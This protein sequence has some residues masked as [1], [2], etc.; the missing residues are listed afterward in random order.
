MKNKLVKL[1]VFV[2]VLAGAFYIFKLFY[3]PDKA[4]VSTSGN[5]GEIREGDLIFQSSF[6]EQGKAIQ[7]A[8]KSVYTHCGIIYKRN[9]KYYVYEAVQPVKLT[10]LDQWIARG[11][12]HHYVIK[13]LSNA[14]QVLIPEA[15]EK[16]KKE[17]EKFLGKN[18][19]STFEWSDTRIYCSE[20]IWKIYKRGT[21]VEIGK[22]EKLKDFDLTGAEVKKK[23]KERY[24]ENIP[25]EETV[26][27]PASVFNSELLITVKEQ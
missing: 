14:D 25:L 12:N 11:K 22:L 13:R 8:T 5:N 16:M 7:Q 20:L 24:G 18:Y 1:L 23:L 6:S 19:D 21:G 2:T 3:N 10:P 17:G 26:I 15:L 9:G 4:M 27:S